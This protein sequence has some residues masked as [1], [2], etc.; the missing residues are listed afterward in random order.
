MTTPRNML[1]SRL[2]K[3]VFWDVFKKV[4]L[5]VK[6]CFWTKKVFLEVCRQQ[7]CELPR[8]V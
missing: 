2:D 6:N 4:F 7:G 3:K 8:V 5:D 1:P